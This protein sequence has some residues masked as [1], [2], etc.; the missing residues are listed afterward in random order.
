MALPSH[1]YAIINVLRLAPILA[2]VHYRLTCMI[3]II[4]DGRSKLGT[5]KVYS[6][7]DKSQLEIHPYTWRLLLVKA[8][9]YIWLVQSAVLV[10]KRR[11]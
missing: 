3:Q 4:P 8:L 7:N 2:Q 10:V 5:E 9:A 6:E 11:W 1:T